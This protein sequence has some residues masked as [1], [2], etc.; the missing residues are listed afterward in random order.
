MYYEEDEKEVDNYYAEEEN[1]DIDLLESSGN[2]QGEGSEES[3]YD[4]MEEGRR[5]NFEDL[6]NDEFGTL[7]MK[8]LISAIIAEFKTQ[9][10]NMTLSE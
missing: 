3:E 7:R 9:Q 5:V 4:D 1:D 2:E 6:T 8:K 10:S